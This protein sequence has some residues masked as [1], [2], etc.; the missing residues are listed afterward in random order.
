[1]KIFASNEQHVEFNI[2]LKIC[3]LVIILMIF[4]IVMI[5]PLVQFIYANF[6]IPICL[7]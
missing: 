4:H 3:V 6:N 7:P 2:Y 1:M 5:L